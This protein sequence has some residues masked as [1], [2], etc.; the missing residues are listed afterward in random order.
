MPSRDPAPGPRPFATRGSQ[1]EVQPGHRALCRRDM[2]QYCHHRR[3]R[4]YHLFSQ[5]FRGWACDIS[6]LSLFHWYVE[7]QHFIIRD[8]S[9]PIV[10]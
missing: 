9:A 1:L 8:S 7:R 4:D 5:L 10:C 2:V 3:Y 6:L